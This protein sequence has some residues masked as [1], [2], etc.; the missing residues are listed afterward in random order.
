MRE[1]YFSAKQIVDRARSR[2][3]S[4]LAELE[5]CVTRRDGNGV[6]VDQHSGAWRRMRERYAPVREQDTRE[7]VA[8]FHRLWAELHARPGQWTGADVE[9]A[10]LERFVGRVPCGD[11]RA[12]WKAYTTANP[13]DLSGPQAYYGWTVAA[14]NAVNRRLGKPEWSG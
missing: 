10:W 2:P 6:W 7:R 12:H 11:C 3:A 13:P 8:H 4:Y 1:V 9:R 5:A 14:H